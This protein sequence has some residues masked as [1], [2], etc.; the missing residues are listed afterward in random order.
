M[1]R[2]FSGT[3]L[4]GRVSACIIAFFM[5]AMYIARQNFPA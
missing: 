5:Y 2:I 1:T 3:F 4:T